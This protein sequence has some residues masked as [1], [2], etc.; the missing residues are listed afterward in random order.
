[1]NYI[2]KFKML[3]LQNCHGQKMFNIT[4]NCNIEHIWTKHLY[5]LIG[6]VSFVTKE[7]HIQVVELIV[8]N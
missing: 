7:L 1:M 3:A 6:V 2:K 4:F 8:K 5:H